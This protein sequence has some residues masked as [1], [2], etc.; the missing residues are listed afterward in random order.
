MS[1]SELVRS[2]GAQVVVLSVA[3]SAIL[4]GAPVAGAQEGLLGSLDLMTSA[5]AAA[6][7]GQWRYHEVTTGTGDQH[8]EIAPKAHGTFDDG[9]WEILQPETLAKGRGPGKYSWCWYRL[10]VTIP[11]QVN[12][13]PF[14]GGPVWFQT[15]VDDYG[16]IWV[17]GQLDRAFGKSGR[18]AVSGFNTRNRVRLQ[19]QT[20]FTTDPQNKKVPLLRD[21]QP[22]D[23]FQLA[24]LGV[25]GPIGNPPGNRIFLRSPTRL[26]FFAAGAANDGADVPASAGPPSG[27]PVAALNLLK[28]EDVQLVQGVWRRHPLAVHTGSNKN[29]IE[30]QAHDAFDDSSWEVVA[31]PALL[32][33]PYGPGKFSMAWYR[34]RITLP[35]NVGDIPL[36]GTAVW[37][38]TTVDDYGE[39]WVNG[40]I[41]LAFGKGGRGAISG[42]NT[43]NEVL[44]TDNAKPGET[45]QIA[46]LAINGPFGNPPGNAIFFRAPTEM[47]FLR[48]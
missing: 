9:M 32:A 48:K 19:K 27:K 28:K 30:P 29:E 1:T 7:K 15:T 41:D 5:G 22:G 34:I 17:D 39:I 2:A 36:A 33:K 11:D 13:K 40:K 20:G 46:V 25:N 37:F 14:T 43:A 18:G 10:Q 3:V 47:R 16:E 35:E 38:R 24:V 8:N 23:V 26:E 6:I 42:F 4:V 12:G 21:P 44:L 31:D 45:I